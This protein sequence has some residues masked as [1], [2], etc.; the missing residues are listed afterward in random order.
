MI[1]RLIFN[2]DEAKSELDTPWLASGNVLLGNI[3]S[4]VV[5]FL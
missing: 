4:S 3:L 1:K 5:S 2:F